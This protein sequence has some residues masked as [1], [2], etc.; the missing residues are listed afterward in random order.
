M[1]RLASLVL[2]RFPLALAPAVVSLLAMACVQNDGTRWTPLET[3]ELMSL[4]DERVLGMEFD[5]ELERHFRLIRDPVVVGFLHDLGQQIVTGVEP[6]PFVYRF[7]VV[8]AP[9]LNAFAVPG[10]YIYFH[11]GTLLA[12]TSVDEL[13]AVMAHEV[14]HVNKRH[15]AH[16]RQDRQLPSLL[17]QAAL[18]AASVASQN[19]APL[20]TGM[21]I[22]VAVDLHYSRTDEAESDRLGAIYASRAGFE[23][24][25]GARFFERILEQ[26]R[27]SPGDIPPYLFSHPAVDER[28]AIYRDRAMTLRPA[29]EPLPGTRERFRAMQARLAQLLDEGRVELPGR[30][31]GLDHSANDA[32]LEAIEAQFDAGQT[33][34]A[35]VGLTQLS[36]TARDDPRVSFRIARALHASGRLDGAIA[37][38][39]HTLELDTGRAMVYYELG[40]AYRDRD[41]R[42]RAVFAFEQAAKRGTRDLGARA[43]WE[44]TKLTFGVVAESGFADDDTAA[45]DETPA[46]RPAPHYR[47]G[48][49]ELVW[50]GRVSGAVLARKDDITVRWVM[51]DGK[52]SA[53][54]TPAADGRLH[55]IARRPLAASERGHFTLEVLIDD[56]VAHRD[57]VDVHPSAGQSARENTGR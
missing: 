50:W 49:P 23:P 2:R 8:E 26:Q 1:R 19:A 54:I 24:A 27:A 12:A 48:A 7:Q 43:R 51:P 42:L 6:Q 32:A 18:I 38:Y 37:A 41:D 4:D 29:R 17:T 20:I 53:P 44:I 57:G 40:R 11:T 33:D 45:S 31:A 39:R 10:G 36:L 34:T 3:F 52:A 13:A 14:A 5:Q 22:N 55:L 25:H 15:L 35:L 28:I 46:G 9:Q 56:H 30:S 47:V 16:R 21:A